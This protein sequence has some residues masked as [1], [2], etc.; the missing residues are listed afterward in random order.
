M[1]HLGQKAR[2]SADAYPQ[3]VFDAN[4]NYVAPSIDPA[5]GSVEIRLGLAG[6]PTFLKPDMTVSVD[7][8]VAAKASVLTLPSDAV[9]GAASTKPWLFAVENDRI[10][11]NDVELG[12]R[13]EGSVEIVSGLR[14]GLEVV[15]PDSHALRVGQRVRS[16][17]EVP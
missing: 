17:R 7:L 4:V 11:R 9:H 15:L 14:E 12:I 16:L 10:V 2:V 1:I 5:R 6:A 8:M 3:Q 13:G